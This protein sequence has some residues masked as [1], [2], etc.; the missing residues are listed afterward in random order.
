M[1]SRHVST[2]RLRY[3]VTI[4]GCMAGKRRTNILTLVCAEM[5]VFTRRIIGFG[6]ERAD[7]CG[8]SVCR[9]FNQII[10]GKPFPR[11]LMTR[12]RARLILEMQSSAGSS[13]SSKRPGQVNWRHVAMGY[14]DFGI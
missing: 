13:W 1:P 4:E 12:T 5:D 3:I 14:G 8:V 2:R 9:M 11:H 10:A 6:V 7:P